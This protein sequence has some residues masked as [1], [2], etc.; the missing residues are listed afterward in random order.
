MAKE[1]KRSHQMLRDFIADVSHELRS[2]LTSIKG[3]ALAITDGTASDDEAK[4]KAAHVIEDESTRMMRLV[5]ELLLFSR[6]ESG[7]ITMIKEPVDLKELM[8]QVYDIY[9]LRAEEN[10]LVFSVDV[11]A[12]PVVMGD[13]D[14]LEQVLNN[15]LDNAFKHTP[16]GGAVSITVEQPSGRVMELQVSDTGPGIPAEQLSHIFERFYR[17]ENAVTKTGSGLGLAIAREIVR[18]H[19][20]TIEV[21]SIL[22]QGTTFT[23]KLP[24]VETGAG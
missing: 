10:R 8:Q 4:Q 16:E 15:L 19:G 20:G 3:F 6:L 12:S 13:I 7:Q 14:R 11:A 17:A 5:D 22:G 2:P 18:A 1:I 23:V 21:K 9:I 24:V